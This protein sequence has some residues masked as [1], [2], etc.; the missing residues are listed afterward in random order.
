MGVLGLLFALFIG[1]F[2]V[3]RA[4]R[5]WRVRAEGGSAGRYCGGAALGNALQELQVFV[6]PRT[7]HVTSER[8]QE[9]VDEDD[10]GEPKDPT[11]HLMRQ[12][13]QI[14]NGEQVERLTTILAP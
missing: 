4:L 1:V 7:E 10:N 2:C 9:A 3:K 8:L 11:G 6:Q 12:A 5:V 13:R 14:R